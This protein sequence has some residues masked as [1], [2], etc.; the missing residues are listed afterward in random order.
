MVEEIRAVRLHDS[1]N[2]RRTG[3]L[4]DGQSISLSSQTRA[5]VPSIIAAVYGDRGR[6]ADRDRPRHGRREERCRVVSTGERRS[7]LGASSSDR[8]SRTSQRTI[9]G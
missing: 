9:G 2:D 4:D 7:R 6:R 1:A 3:S 5:A 8:V